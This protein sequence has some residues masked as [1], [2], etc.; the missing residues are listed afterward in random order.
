[1]ATRQQSTISLRVAR[2]FPAP[3]DRI[4][5]AWTRAEELKRWSCPPDATVAL[6]EVD[7]R[8]GGRFRIHMVGGTGIEHRVVG[9]YREIDPPHRLVYTWQW[10]TDAHPTETLVTVEFLQRPGGTEVV[11]T[12]ERFP[13]TES[14]D[15]HQ[16]G[17][18]GC[19]EHLGKALLA[20]AK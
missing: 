11:L 7:L 18:G 6:A 17:W 3:P 16:H 9:E 15:Q 8:V 13:T 10:E 4:F 19:L 12:H 1:M 14:R 20:Q 5:K 2:T